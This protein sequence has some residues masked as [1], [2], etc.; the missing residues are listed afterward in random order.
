[1]AMGRWIISS[2]ALATALVAGGCAYDPETVDDAYTVAYEIEAARVMEP[3][4]PL[5]N[6]GLRPGYFEYADAMWSENDYGD[7]WHFAFKA[8]DSAEG[9]QVLPDLV[10]ERELAA[11]N[12]EEL[13]IGRARLMGALGQTARKKAPIQAAVAQVAFDCWL[14]RTEDGDPTD[15]IEA[16][17]GQFEEALADI[18]RSLV[19]DVDN[20]YL[21]F[22]AWDQADI[23]PVAR[24]VLDQ[25]Q[26]DFARGQRSRL[27]IA[28][29]ADRSGPAD[30]NVRLSEQRAR[31]VA[32]ALEQMGLPGDAMNL[33]WY[34]ETDPRVPTADG[35]REP[36]NR[37]VEIVF[38]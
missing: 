7:Y 11:A 27:V 32:R 26:A 25:V 23:S 29:H 1:M 38:G 12:A 17:R 33:E 28:G 2:L 8:V 5:F 34:G 6:R 9:E 16:C 35:V 4:G 36:Q 21:V 30:Y 37:R 31:A 24:T 3:Q 13:A 10:E 18:E 15:Q 14:E 20:V 19:S 22:F